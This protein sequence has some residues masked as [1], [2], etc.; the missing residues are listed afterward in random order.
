[1]YKSY[2]LNICSTSNSKTIWAFIVV[3]I[4][5]RFSSNVQWIAERIA[6]LQWNAIIYGNNEL[7]DKKGTINSVRFDLYCAMLNQN[8]VALNFLIFVRITSLAILCLMFT[9]T[10]LSL[11]LCFKFALDVVNLLQRLSYCVSI[12]EIL[13]WA[14]DKKISAPLTPLIFIHIFICWNV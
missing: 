2:W 7:H 6:N 8:I 14:T 9:D 3:F 12:S 10:I 4:D 13:M 1:M 11:T 5:N